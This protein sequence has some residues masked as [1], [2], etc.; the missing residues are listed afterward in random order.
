MASCQG[1][2]KSA[3][4]S[5]PCAKNGNAVLANGYCASHQYQAIEQI[6]QRLS[7][8]QRELQS[9]QTNSGLH[10]YYD[11]D[12]AALLSK[13]ITFLSEELETA[14]KLCAADSNCSTHM[15]DLLVTMQDFTTPVPP[16]HNSAMDRLRELEAEMSGLSVGTSPE[17][18]VAFQI[19]KQYE[20]NR[21]RQYETTQNIQELKAQ[22]EDNVARAYQKYRDNEEREQVLNRTLQQVSDQREQASAT[23]ASLQSQLDRCQGESQQ[24][25]GVYTQ[26]IQKLKADVNKYKSLYDNMVAREIRL[27][28]SVTQLTENE[29][30]LQA[31][32]NKL[33]LQYEADT[34]KLRNSF[35]EQVEAGGQVLSTREEAL[36]E[37]VDKL[38]ADLELALNDLKM[39]TES[40][41]RALDQAQSKNQPYGQIA[42]E[43]STVSGMLRAKNEELN[44]LQQLYDQRTSEFASA[45]LK[46]AERIEQATATDRAEVQRL[47]QELATIQRQLATTKQETVSLQTEAYNLRRQNENQ[48]RQLNNQLRTAQDQLRSSQRQRETEQ[49]SIQ[50]QQRLMNNQL[51]SLQ[52]QQEFKFNQLKTQLNDKY[53]AREQELR[54]RAEDNEQRLRQ[55]RESLASTQRQMQASSEELARQRDDLERYRQA[56]DEK[57]AEF[58]QI[59]TELTGKLTQAESQLAD[60]AKIEADYKRQLDMVR[61]SM[62]IE[63]ERAEA[64]IKQLQTKLKQAYDSRNQTIS[65]L[66]QCSAAR[67]GIVAKVS[68][69]TQEN[70]QLKGALQQLQSRMDV[71]RAQYEATLGKVRANA[72]KM[73][74]DL[75]LCASNLEEVTAAHNHVK[76]EMAQAVAL[77]KNLQETIRGAQGNEQALQRL[78]KSRE[79]QE[80]EVSRLQGALQ[81]CAS[82][83]KRTQNNLANTNSELRDMKRMHAE[84]SNEVQDLSTT[85]QRAF[86]EREA[87]MEQ[88][89]VQ[90]QVRESSLQQQLAKYRYRNAAQG[91]EVETLQKRNE[92]VADTLADTEVH[93]AEQVNNLLEAQ[94]LGQTPTD[95]PGTGR[96]QLVET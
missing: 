49:R 40:G 70:N 78:I 38:K 17:D 45:E 81:E 67:D 36:S 71:M 53:A 68:T 43:L 11:P 41:K 90:N 54:D 73:E 26:T 33:Q 94:R 86:A 2:V 51:A 18:A 47:S 24:V 82:E 55:E 92:L 4:G 50:E 44:R 95:R 6:R 39:A 66:Q 29:K 46:T 63:G 96:S 1:W 30:T 79:L 15:R 60:F 5:R 25:S 91:R 87:A 42:R 23:V 69:L 22:Y 88:Q 28:K 83:R 85:Y 19:A 62:R 20:L 93:H 8:T 12:K 65:S 9:I 52:A 3:R 84:L 75:R 57:L 72:S 21:R 13:Q 16:G 32:L 58:T 48:I 37:Q 59:K 76:R 31:A 61:Q 27:S 35:A 34:E 80:Q 64:R 7:Q 77:R 14:K 74:S 10:G 56:Y 89:A